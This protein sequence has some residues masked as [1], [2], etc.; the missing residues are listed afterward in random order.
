MTEIALVDPTQGRQLTQ[1]QA[2]KLKKS[3]DQFK[4]ELIDEDKQSC[5]KQ[6]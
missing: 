6:V 1:E 3:L 5:N 2:D 4:N